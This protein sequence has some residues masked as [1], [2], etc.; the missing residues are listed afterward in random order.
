[1]QPRPLRLLA[2]DLTAKGF[3]FAL[4]DA[5]LGLLDWGFSSLLA[6]DDDLFLERVSARIER[7]RPTALVLE[8]FAPIKGRETAL[9]RRDLAIA[10]AGERK[11]GLCQVSQKIV[12]G[13]LGP[14]TKAEIARVLV[15]RFPELQ[16][17]MPR[18]RTRWSTEDERMHIFDALALAVVVMRPSAEPERD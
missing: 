7:G 9:R 10:L 3:G 5:R 4:L 12:Q 13:I 14:G 1:M 16:H 17:R 11:I 6:S 18:E 2:I 15:Q 8:N